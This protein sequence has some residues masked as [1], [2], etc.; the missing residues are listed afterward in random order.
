[1]AGDHDLAGAAVAEGE[2]VLRQVAL[3]ALDLAARVALAHDLAQLLLAVGV[4]A[5]L[6]RGRDAKRL[7]DEVA[8][9]VEEVHERLG[10]EVEDAHDRRHDQRGRG[11]PSDR[12]ALRR[13]LAEHDVQQRDDQEGEGARERDAGDPGVLPEHRLEQVVEGPLTG[14]AEAQAG[15]RDAELTSRE[16]GVDVVDGVADGPRAGASLALPSGDLAGPDPRQ[17][18]LRGDEEAVQRHERQGDDEVQTGHVS[19]VRG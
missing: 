19:V 13:E 11:G 18:E 12:E 15:D 14:D 10:G 1:V 6:P 17:R 2:D 9:A 7:E 4:V 3:V 8:H 5:G 16:V